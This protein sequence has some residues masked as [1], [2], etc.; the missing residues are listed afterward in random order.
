M[1]APSTAFADL[2]ERA[3]NEPGIVSAAYRQF[4]N[5]S[6]GNQ[7]SAAAQCLARGLQ[8][9]PMATYPKWRELGRHVRKGE[10]AITLCQPVTIKRSSLAQSRSSSGNA[11][12]NA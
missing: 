6:L 4:H 11:S 1:N 5:Y 3:V 7:L 12:E 10:Q 8:P 9:G 2:L